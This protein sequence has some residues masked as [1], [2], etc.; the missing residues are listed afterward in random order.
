[1][2]RSRLDI[3]FP[4][5]QQRLFCC[6]EPYAAQAGEFLLNHARSGI[7]LA[8][9]ALHLPENSGVGVMVY[10]CH[11]VFNAIEQVGMRPVFIDV[12]PDLKIDTAD[13]QHKAQQIKALVVT[14]LFGIRN[15]VAAIR[16]LCPDLPIVEDCAHACGISPIEGDLAVF[17]IGQGKLPSIGDGGILRVRNPQYLPAVNALYEQLQGYGRMQNVKLFCRMWLNALMHTRLVYSLLTLPLKSRRGAVAS[18]VDITPHRMSSGVSAIYNVE[19]KYT[20][21]RIEKRRTHAATLAEYVAMQEGVERTLVGDNAFMLVVQCNNP[22]AF[23]RHLRVRGIDSAT[24]FRH[25]ITWATDFGYQPGSCPNAE[26]LTKHLL[27]LPTYKS[28]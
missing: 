4:F 11:T 26:Q 10:N 21:Q 13:L 27:M 18:R 15:D 25:C 5:R 12:T 19:R 20:D 23:Q 17:S 2:L 7:M 9:K 1:M 14:H 16:R 8:L 22:T 3:H 6:G 24:H 28:M